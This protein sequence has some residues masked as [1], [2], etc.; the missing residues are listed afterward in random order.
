MFASATH[1]PD[2]A[3]TLLAGLAQKQQAVADVIRGRVSLLE[4]AD[5]F[6]IAG[7]GEKN[8]E[9][10]CRSVIGWVELKLHDRPE[11]AALVADRLERELQCLLARSRRLSA[12]A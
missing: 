5:R 2:P 1:S 4:A 12:P 8:A 11:R 7:G 6:R 3:P 10:L 9:A